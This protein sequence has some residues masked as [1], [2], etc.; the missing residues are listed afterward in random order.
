MLSSEG[1]GSVAFD[2]SDARTRIVELE[3]KRE[4]QLVRQRRIDQVRKGT[5]VGNG[6][7]K[8]VQP[9][10]NSGRE[11]MLFASGA[12]LLVLFFTLSVVWVIIKLS[13]D[14]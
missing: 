14:S 4:Q 2:P 10:A 9:Q 6:N 11:V 7:G 8:D 12:L 1:A 13:E 3:Q 5:A